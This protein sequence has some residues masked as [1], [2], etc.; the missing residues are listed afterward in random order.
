MSYSRSLNRHG[1]SFPSA[2]RRMRLHSP[3]KCLLIGLMKPTVP[4]APENSK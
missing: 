2:V 3:Q 4:F 1:R